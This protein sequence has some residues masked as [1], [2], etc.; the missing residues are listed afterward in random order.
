MTYLKSQFE[1]SERRACDVVSIHRSSY[2]HPGRDEIDD[3]YAEVVRLSHQYPYWGYRKTYDLID[4]EQYPIGRERVRLIRR[5]EG[6]QVVQ[7]PKKK[8]VLGLTTQ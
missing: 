2:R 5:R 1:V 7:K 6:L 4:R 8:R 3:T